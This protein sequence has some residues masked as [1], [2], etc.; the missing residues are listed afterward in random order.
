MKIFI[1]HVNVG[2]CTNNSDGKM[3]IVAENEDIAKN[4]VKQNTQ[5][6][7]TLVEEYTLNNEILFS[8]FRTQTN[9]KLKGKTDN[10]GEWRNP[11]TN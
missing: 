8:T 1:V 6:P 11:I 10:W 2:C 7:I 3:W 5:H 9:Y 4:I